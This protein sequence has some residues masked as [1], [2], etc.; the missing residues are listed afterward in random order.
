MTRIEGAPPRGLFARV[1]YW[2]VKHKVGK[3]TTPVRVMG[4]HPKVLVGY[5]RMEQAFAASH[6]LPAQIKLLAQV[7]TSTLLGCPF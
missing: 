2:A 1:I 5:G 7:R 4:H 3:V 6:A